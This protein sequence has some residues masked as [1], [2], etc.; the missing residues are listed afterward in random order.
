M[1]VMLFQRSAFLIC[2]TLTFTFSNLTLSQ[3][4][5]NYWAPLAT[6]P[7]N[8]AHLHLPTDRS[9]MVQHATGTMTG[10]TA[11]YTPPKH[12]GGNGTWVAGPDFPRQGPKLFTL[13]S[14][15]I[16]P[17]NLARV[18]SWLWLMESRLDDH[19][20]VHF[21][22]RIAWRNSGLQKRKPT[23]LSPAVV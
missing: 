8:C 12:E 14:S 22:A 16:P 23:K 15:S 20:D 7:I 11:I 10:H 5:P 1:H 9:V 3:T 17:P 13:T 18:R 21:G 2:L 4:L 19:A 6:A